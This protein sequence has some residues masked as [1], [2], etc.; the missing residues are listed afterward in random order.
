LLSWNDASETEAAFEIERSVNGGPFQ[1]LVTVPRNTASFLDSNVPVGSANRYRVRGVSVTAE[2]DYSNEAEVGSDSSPVIIV[3]PQSRLVVPGSEVQ[4]RVAASGNAPLSYAW[5]HE[6]TALDG[7]T[8]DLLALTGVQPGQAGEY[9][10]VVT[11][12][13]GSTATSAVAR[14]TVAL[15]PTL[16]LTSVAGASNHLFT[17]GFE[18]PAEVSYIVEGST[19]LIEW[20]PLQTNGTGT[21]LIGF[22]DSAVTHVP[23]RFY[24]AILRP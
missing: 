14:L 8:N 12:S 22:T 3:Q 5:W 20:L 17:F 11:D 15:P 13:A 2:S 21:G 1:P 18:A 16:S 19:N 24:R 23:Q 6:A 9:R 7:E 10:V 4:F